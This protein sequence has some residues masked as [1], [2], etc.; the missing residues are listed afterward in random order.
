[1]PLMKN[2]ICFI[3]V[4]TYPLLKRIEGNFG[5]AEVDL[6]LLAKE[7]AN[8]VDYEVEFIVGDYGQPDIELIDNIIVKKLKYMNLNMYNKFIHKIL[9][10]FYFIK[11][12]LR[13]KANIFFSEGASEILGYII[14][15]GKLLSRKKVIFRTASDKD[16][17]GGHASKKTFK[18]FMY[19]NSIRF[20]DVIIAQN[21]RQKKIWKSVMNLD[22]LVIK[23]GMAIPQNIAYNNKH[24][25]LW[26]A[27]SVEL[28]RPDLFLKMAKAL[29]EHNFV[30]ILFGKNELSKRIKIKSKSINN[31]T[32]I[33]YVPFFNIQA[34]YDQAL[35]FVNTSEYEGF[36]NSFLQ[37][38]IG[39]T[40]L[41][42]LK[43]NPDNFITKYN[44]GTCCNQ[45]IN[46]GIEFIKYLTREKLNLYGKNARDYLLK[47]HDISKIMVDYDLLINKIIKRSRLWF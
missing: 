9:R 2:K 7:F 45:N 18:G 4:N 16:C 24:F 19:K 21:H 12:L 42:S 5:G 14:I 29:P 40:P 17:D 32:I 39:H 13:S 25:I 43:V 10:R 11:V 22:S 6:Y 31:L 23:N 38:L 15:I 34:Y 37:A 44:L 1:M 27:R 28:K 35:C 41:L 33:D 26:A 30:M 36:P 47:H 20:A 3:S 46:K 8:M